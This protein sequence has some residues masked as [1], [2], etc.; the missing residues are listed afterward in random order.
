MHTRRSNMIR[1][2]TP[3]PSNWLT[4]QCCQ[5]EQQAREDDLLEGM[6]YRAANQRIN[7]LI[8]TYV[9]TYLP[10]DESYA[11]RRSG[12]CRRCRVPSSSRI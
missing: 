1:C 9:R 12:S 10:L 7:S 11:G 5:Q 2:T 4:I 8:R 3:M 6:Q